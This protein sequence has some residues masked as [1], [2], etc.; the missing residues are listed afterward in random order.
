M[1]RLF[2]ARVNCVEKSL[3][4]HPVCGTYG[5]SQTQ[6]CVCERQSKYM[7]E[8]KNPNKVVNP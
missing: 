1:R 3:V 4:T 2:C 5:D 6:V 8:K 7:K